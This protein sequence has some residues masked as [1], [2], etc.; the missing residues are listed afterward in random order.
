SGELIDRAVLAHVIADL[1]PTGTAEGT[2]AIGALNRLRAECR[3]AKERLSR[4]SVTTLP[5]D[6]S[7]HRGEVRLTRAEL[8]NEIRD[9]LASF[10]E[11][12]REHL[13]R[14]RIHPADLAAV[15]TIGGGANIP[16]VTTALSAQLRVPV[17]TVA[18]PE[19]TAATGAA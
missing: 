6:V 3:M 8:D 4:S 11:V 18:R 17:I 1:P 7:G 12:L 5:V 14:D 9:P 2:S 15:A 10:I 19:L 13:F 16:A